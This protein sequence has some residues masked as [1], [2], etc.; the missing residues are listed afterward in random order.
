MISIDEIEPHRRLPES[1]LT[2]SG[3]VDRD[4]FQCNTLGSP[5]SWMRIAL[6]ILEVY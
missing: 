1:D 2:G 5:S 4:I 3:I 6:A